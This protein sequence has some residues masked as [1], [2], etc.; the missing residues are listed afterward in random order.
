MIKIN[1]LPIESFRQKASGQMSVTIYAICMLLLFGALYVCNLL[2]MSPKKSSLESAKNDVTQKVNAAKAQATKAEQQTSSYVDKMVKVMVIMELEERRR[3]QAKLFMSLAN[4]ITSQSSWLTSLAHD[5]NVLTIKGRAT[6]GP[7]VG[8]LLTRLNSLSYLKNS[9]LGPI[10]G[11]EQINGIAV[12]NFD[13]RAQTYFPPLDYSVAGE[14]EKLLPD[15]ARV[16]ELVTAI[17][18]DLAQALEAQT[19]KLKPL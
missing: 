19:Q 14:Q 7:T 17:S 1:L 5:Q 16:K 6:N 10:L 8:L 13:M 12:F 3:D 9:E 18:P 4:E 15:T 11:G 2:Y